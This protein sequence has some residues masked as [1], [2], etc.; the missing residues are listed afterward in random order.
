MSLPEGV[1][2]VTD[3]VLISLPGGDNSV[4]V[5]TIVFVTVFFE[6]SSLVLLEKVLFTTGL[7]VLELPGVSMHVAVVPVGV[8]AQGLAQRHELV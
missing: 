8:G 5:N 4:E 7:S 3:G 1:S 2:A 6:Y